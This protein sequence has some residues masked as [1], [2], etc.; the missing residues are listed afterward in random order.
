MKELDKKFYKKT[1]RPDRQ[2]SYKMIA[3]YIVNNIKPNLTSVIDY[4]CG[5]GWFLYYLKNEG[6]VDVMGIEPNKEIVSV[7]DDS[8]KDDIKF[9]D[10]TKQ[11]YIDRK[12][13][14]AMNIEVVEHIDKK[15]SDLVIENITRHTDLLI[16]SAATPGQGGYGHINEQSFEYW[17]EKLNKVGFYCDNVGTKH[18][19]GYLKENKA[20][21][22]YVNNISIF[23][24]AR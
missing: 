17:E 23:N 12:F 16:F 2:S 18:F 7:L 11:V 19:R 5:A 8:I 21:R 14:V 13:D 10:L 22:W 4:G 9:L 15:Y 20:K 6:V 1:L 3:S 24:K